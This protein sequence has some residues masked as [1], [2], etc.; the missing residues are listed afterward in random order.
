MN[1]NLKSVFIYAKAVLPHM[2][3][4][5]YG[6]IVSVAARP[7]VE[8]NGWARSGDSGLWKSLN[9]LGLKI[10]CGLAKVRL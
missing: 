7:A 4:E 1:I 3:K 5:N 10:F 9:N 6:R 2:I 8:K